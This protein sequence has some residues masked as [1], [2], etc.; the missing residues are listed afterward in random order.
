MKVEFV[1]MVC[2]GGKRESG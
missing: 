2:S 1:V